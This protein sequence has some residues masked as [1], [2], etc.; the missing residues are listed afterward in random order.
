MEGIAAREVCLP[1]QL[2]Q[3]LWMYTLNAI[4][5]QLLLLNKS[6]VLFGLYLFS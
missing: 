6:R 4:E 1:V 5:R 2:N 3:F